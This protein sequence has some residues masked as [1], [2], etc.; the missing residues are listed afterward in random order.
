M[1]TLVLF[2][3]DGTLVDSREVLISCWRE[4]TLEVIGRFYPETPQE[5]DLVSRVR[6]VDLFA[7][8]TDDPEAADA[9]GAAFQR[10]YADRQVSLFDGALGMLEELRE[11]GHELGVVTSKSRE[12]FVLDSLATRLDSTFD[13]TVCGEDVVHAKPDPEGVLRAVGQLEG[14]PARTIHVGDTLA[15]T[16][17]GAAAGVS[18]IAAGWGYGDPTVLAAEAVAA[19]ASDPGE[20]AALVGLIFSTDVALP[21]Q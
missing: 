8:L 21:D 9:L 12:R 7:S 2:D 15:D 18:V 1:K 10:A 6:G 14:T 4:A 16:G 20:V 17:A 11:A 5:R 3:W 19:V 13:V